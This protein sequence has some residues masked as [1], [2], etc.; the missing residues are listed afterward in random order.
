MTQPV[1]FVSGPFSAHAMQAHEVPQLQHFF[2][3]NPIYFDAVQGQVP[4][5]EEAQKEFDDLPPPD[6]PFAERWMLAVADGEGQWVAMASVLS[7]FIAP[8]VWHIG[9]FIVATRLHG[10]GAAASLYGA[11]EQWMHSRGA[12]WVRL[13]AVQGWAKAEN[14]WSKQGYIQVRTRD[15]IAMGQRVND[16]RVMVKPLCSYTL[17][18]YLQHVLRDNPGAA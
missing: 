7:D 13:G 8:G 11:L 6:M 5:A 18:E 17:A 3:D 2:E 12:Q 16:V 10:T 4:T 9:L 15:A 14:F 1:I